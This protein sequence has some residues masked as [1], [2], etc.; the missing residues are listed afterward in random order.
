MR[1]AKPNFNLLQNFRSVES[2][3]IFYAFDILIHEGQDL[4]Q[5]PLSKRRAILATAIKPSDHVGLSYVSD[6]TAAQ[7]VNFVRSHGLKE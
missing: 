3:I 7:M 2:H 1:R 6:E 4:K 5:L